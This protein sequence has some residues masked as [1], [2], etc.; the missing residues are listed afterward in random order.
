MHQTTPLQDT[1]SHGKEREYSSSLN[2][3]STTDPKSHIT[4]TN[5]HFCDVAGYQAED[6]YGEPHNLVRHPDMPKAAFA[7]LWQYV[8]SGKSWM[9]VVKNSCKNGDH[10]WVSAFVTP[11]TDDKGRVV[12]YQSVR[13]QP[14]RDE[15][16][17]ASEIYSKIK[18]NQKAG[19][20]TRPRLRQGYILNSLLIATMGLAAYQMFASDFNLASVG[21]L[22]ISSLALGLSGKMG[23]RQAAINELAAKAYDN[24]LME[25]VYTG[26]KDDYSVVELALRM[27]QA[28]LRAIVGRASETS[29]DI[30]IS[31]EDERANSQEIKTNLARQTQATEQ[32]GVA[33]GQMSISIREVAESA[34][35]ASELTSQ[36]QSMS[37]GGQQRVQETIDSVQ[38]LHSELDNSKQVIN[39]LSDSSRQIESILDVI[40]SIADQT[41]LLALNAAIEAAR[42]GEAGRGFAVVADEVRSLAQKTQTSTE[43][44]QAMITNLQQTAAQAVNAVERGGDLSEQCR[45]QALE[46]GDQLSQINDMLNRVTDNSHQI[47]AAVEEQ[48]GVSDDIGRNVEQIN[49]L[50]FATSSVSDRAVESTQRL[51]ERL[52]G[53]SRLMKQFQR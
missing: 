43:E 13:S 53:L 36:A 39:A 18:H 26:R 29:A 33:M 20:A 21:L 51:V 10:Y 12:E 38:A 32:V 40:G 52:E 28:E 6:M 46:T 35:Q 37:E 41:N 31:A 44:I 17:R 24:P 19:V 2:L 45:V 25:A 34:A 8:Q 11:I 3:I 16:N 7:Q 27:R 50:S 5:Q 22:A 23:Q 42:A 15:I 49:E 30:L 9:G 48:A 47:A 4:Y 1:Q 14:S